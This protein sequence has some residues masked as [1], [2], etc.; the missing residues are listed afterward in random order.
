[1]SETDEPAPG[2]PTKRRR[3][4]PKGSRNKTTAAGTKPG[5]P[6]SAAALRDALSSIDGVAML[7]EVVEGRQ[8]RTSGPTGR[9]VLAYPT[10]AER[11][12]AAEIWARKLVP[13]LSTHAVTGADGQS[14]VQIEAEDVSNRDI[15]RAIL[16]ILRQAHLESTNQEVIDEQSGH[17]SDPGDEKVPSLEPASPVTALAATSPSEPL[18]RMLTY[19]PTTGQLE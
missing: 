15:A 17:V 13:D 16:E 12:K 19:N 2:E 10:I 7:K 3:G 6:W 18:R 9:T 11:L 1:M 14:P 4:R 8:I 5:R